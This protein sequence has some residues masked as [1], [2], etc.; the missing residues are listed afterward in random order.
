MRISLY[1][2]CILTANYQEVFDTKIREGHTTSTFEDYLAT[3]DRR[4]YDI[5]SFLTD[6]GSFNI[7]YSV[8][9]LEALSCN[10]LKITD[11]SN[12]IYAFVDSVVRSNS[13][14]TVNYT[15]DVFHTYFPVCSLRDSL[16]SN[17]RKKVDGEHAELPLQ[18]ISNNVVTF[19]KLTQNTGVN[20]IVQLSMYQLV[21]GGEQEPSRDTR[22]CLIQR[23]SSEGGSATINFATGL[24][25]NI[26]NELKQLESSNT[27][28]YN[29]KT[30]YYEIGEVY[31]IPRD[32]GIDS[33]FD[34]V[35]SFAQIGSSGGL[36]KYIFRRTNKQNAE[37]LELLSGSIQNDYKNLGIG[38]LTSLVKFTSN[39]TEINYEIVCSYNSFE[40]CIMLNI[41][42]TI[43]DVTKV[44]AIEVPF[45]SVTGE[46]AVSRQIAKNTQIFKGINS[47]FKGVTQIGAGLSTGAMQVATAG[48]MGGALTKTMLYGGA[49]QSGVGVIGGIMTIAEGI[50]EIG[51]ANTE[52]NQ[53]TYGVNSDSIGSL[54][55]H[56][57]LVIF[58]I[59]SDNDLEVNNA[60][61]EIGYSVFYKSNDLEYGQSIE[62]W[63]YNVVRF[64]NAKVVGGCPQVILAQIKQILENGV[65]VWYTTNVS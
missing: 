59:N 58:K 65:K 14:V 7:A 19:E 41:A 42:G 36:F 50:H 34:T 60:I 27:L 43:Y 32:F 29:N 55:A 21:S 22:F 40:F 16:I 6:S 15:V 25:S 12:K 33:I 48:A 61:N 57:G 49:V 24:A 3:L 35:G 1:K 64:I 28:T 23:E 39:N 53:N 9:G 56:Y 4:D 11:G 51:I 26:L 13:C 38:F 63:D 46:Q 45:R 20:I 62:D 30:Y 47:I 54:N 52:K 2:G 31:Y 8:G 17:F 18:Y 44:F 37:F 5:N 10:Y